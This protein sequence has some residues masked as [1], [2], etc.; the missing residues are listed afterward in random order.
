MSRIK[1][2]F[3]EGK[4]DEIDDLWR[5]EVFE[6][7]DGADGQSTAREYLA[8]LKEEVPTKL[9]QNGMEAQE[10]R[11]RSEELEGRQKQAAEILEL[12]ELEAFV[13]GDPPTA[14]EACIQLR[15]S[16][17]GAFESRLIE[18]EITDGDEQL[19]RAAHL[20]RMK[21]HFANLDAQTEWALSQVHEEER[22]WV[23]EVIAEA[24]ID[25]FLAGS[26]ARSFYGKNAEKLAVRALNYRNTASL[27]GKLKGAANKP[28]REAILAAMAAYRNRGHSLGNA[29]E[30]TAKQG[31]GTSKDAN[32]KMWERYRG[33]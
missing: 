32:K 24:T 9:L 12:G 10:V 14:Q 23:R 15:E 5:E 33:S 2:L 28:Q 20:D 16:V 21:S 8:I 29:A 11:V 4:L 19:S 7:G 25:A 1:E 26:E 13:E 30:L 18:G 22:R 3:D 6:E 31:L 17:L 27:G